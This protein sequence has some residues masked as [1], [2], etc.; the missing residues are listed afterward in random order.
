MEQQYTAHRYLE[1]LRNEN[2]GITIKEKDRLVTIPL[3]LHLCRVISTIHLVD[4]SAEGWAEAQETGEQAG[5]TTTG[6]DATGVGL[7]EEPAEGTGEV[8]TESCIHDKTLTY[9][10]RSRRRLESRLEKVNDTLSRSLPHNPLQGGAIPP[11]YSPPCPLHAS[12]PAP[13]RSPVFSAG[14]LWMV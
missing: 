13:T 8:S 3:E 1:K 14:G 4:W 11:Q 7:P 5:Q 10:N 9:H 12:T 2:E 6:A